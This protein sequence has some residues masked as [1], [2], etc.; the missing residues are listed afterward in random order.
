MEIRPGTNADYAE[1]ITLIV[2][3]T[4]EALAEYGIIL[5]P[6]KLQKTFDELLA[7]SFTAV[8]EGKVVGIFAG[9][10][11][12]DVCSDLPVYEEIIWYM[13]KK[14]RRHGVKLLRHV[15][16]WCK[17]RGI[18]RM[19]LALTHNSKAEK[20][21]KFYNRLGFKAQETRFVGRI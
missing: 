3:F 8:V 1:A 19:V 20:I 16:A 15:M 14:Y 21:T 13:N 5:D 7:T 10:V 9:R 11:G 12:T 2:E 4:E 17:E 18:E 6:Q